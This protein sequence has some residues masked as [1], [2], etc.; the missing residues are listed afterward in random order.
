V[1]TIMTDDRADGRWPERNRAHAEATLRGAIMALDAELVAIRARLAAL[2][3]REQHADPGPASRDGP[4]QQVTAREGQAGG[5]TAPIPAADVPRLRWQAWGA[6]GQTA[7]AIALLAVL[8][9]WLLRPLPGTAHPGWAAPAP[10]A[11][12]VQASASSPAPTIVAVPAMRA[13][14]W[15]PCD[16]D[17]DA[18]CPWNNDQHA[19]APPVVSGGDEACPAPMTPS[20]FPGAEDV[21]GEGCPGTMS[22]GRQGP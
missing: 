9:G 16:H 7:L 15:P 19:A 21:F 22:G 12:P 14:S 2:E 8:L 20:A 18:G 5:A 17:S 6:R 3:A 11:A 13:V 10:A 1:E 4:S